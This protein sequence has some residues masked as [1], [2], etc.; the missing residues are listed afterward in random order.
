[1]EGQSAGETLVSLEATVT[2][3]DELVYH[4]LALEWGKTL[5]D[6]LVQSWMRLEVHEGIAYEDKVGSQ[7][8]LLDE[9][10]ASLFHLHKTLGRFSQQLRDHQRQLR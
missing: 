4:R 3:Q 8:N 10:T 7:L 5:L 6:R 2:I 1:M 9:A